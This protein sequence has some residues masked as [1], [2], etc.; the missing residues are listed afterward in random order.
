MTQ[1]EMMALLSK[2]MVMVGLALATNAPQALAQAQ[3]ADSPNG[4]LRAYLQ[5]LQACDHGQS[6]QPDAALP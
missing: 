6:C 1:Q 3:G 2:S 4:A 5:Y